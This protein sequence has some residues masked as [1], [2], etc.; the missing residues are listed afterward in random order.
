MEYK[1]I[2]EAVEVAKKEYEA[3]GKKWTKE[4]DLQVR[5]AHIQQL[6]DEGLLGPKTEEKPDGRILFDNDVINL[7]VIILG[8]I[9]VGFIINLIIYR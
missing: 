7:I 4:I 9:F 8:V 1:T 5:R 6:R 2:G 3:A